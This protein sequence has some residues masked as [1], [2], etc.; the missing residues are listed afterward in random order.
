MTIT[1][2]VEATLTPVALTY[3]VGVIRV[4][5]VGDRDQATRKQYTPGERARRVSRPRHTATTTDRFKSPT[6]QRDRINQACRNEGL[7]LAQVFPE[8]DVKGRWPLRRRKGLLKA[9]EAIEAGHAKV[10][11][12]A[13]FDRLVRSLEVQREV[14]ARIEKAGGMVL[15]VDAG[16][17]ATRTAAQWLSSTLLG[18]VAEYYSR[19]VGERLGNTQAMSIADGIQIG[20]IPPGYVQDPET[21]RLVVVPEEK[22][23]MREAFKMRAD[24]AA[25]ATVRRY[26]AEH[27]IVRSVGSVSKLL[28][29]K[30]YLGWVFHGK[31]VNTAA[32][33]PI[34]DQATFD[35]VERRKGVSFGVPGKRAAGLLSGLRLLKCGTCG[36]SLTA[37]Q[38]VQGG[39]SYPLYRC[40][41]NLVCSKRTSIDARI[42]DVFVKGYVKELVATRSVT[43]GLGM[44]MLQARAAVEAAQ[45][46]LNT[47]VVNLATVKV[48]SAAQVLSALQVALDQAND[49]LADLERRARLLGDSQALVLNAAENFDDLSLDEQRDIISAVLERVDVTPG[50]VDASGRRLPRGAGRLHPVERQSLA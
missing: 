12:V 2:A 3:A 11:V 47:A 32:H 5:E 16:E 31:Y 1:Q 24:G 45:D 20:S 49:R 28:H 6:E 42:A 34:I 48:A 13:Y 44:E 27:G 14:L 43:E 19:S 37:G 23:V 40:N 26:M 15:A 7:E 30:T 10:L 21:R 17:V 50:G 22:E 18:T 36:K 9:I 38:Q 41:P 33:E 35:R 25:W 29:S 8:I 39:K 46:A 4:S